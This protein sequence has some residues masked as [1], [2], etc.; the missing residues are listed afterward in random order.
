MKMTIIALATIMLAGCGVIKEVNDVAKDGPYASPLIQSNGTVL[1]PENYLASG[2][3]Y[4][5]DSKEYVML[6]D[7]PHVLNADKIST[8]MVVDETMKNVV[9]STGIPSDSDIEGV[10]YKGDGVIY[11]ISESGM[12]YVLDKESKGWAF[13]ETLP[14]INGIATKVSSLAID[15]DSGLMYTAE[16]EGKKNLYVMNSSG[17][18]IETITLVLPQNEFNASIDSDYTISGMAYKSGKLIILSEAYSTVFFYDIAKKRI[19]SSVGLDDTHEAAGI[20]INGNKLVTVGDQE[21]YLPAPVFS[22]F[23]IK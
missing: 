6:S 16:K 19:V 13:R 2:I 10:G 8:L 14:G 4:D 9:Y 3:T 20:A 7:H 18:L 15:T 22:E 21:D 12:I 1:M 11:S 5:W 23:N 17:E